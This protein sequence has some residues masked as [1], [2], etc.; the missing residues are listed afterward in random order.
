MSDVE[1]SGDAAA[2]QGIRFNIAQLFMTYYGEDE[3]LNVGPKG[4]TGEKYGGAT[5]WD[6]EAYIV[7]MYLGITNPS[8][9]KAL[10]QYRHNQLPG[11]YHNAKE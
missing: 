8:V 1:I 10:L 2:Q 11:S 6:T 9:T 7:P 5:Y 4:F 3:R